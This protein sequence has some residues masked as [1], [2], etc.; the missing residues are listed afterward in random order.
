MNNRSIKLNMHF[1]PDFHA[2][3]H[4]DICDMANDD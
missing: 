3:A 4:D 1:K 2:G